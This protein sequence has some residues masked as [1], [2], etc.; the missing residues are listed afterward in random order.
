MP[1]PLDQTYLWQTRLSNMMFLYSNCQILMPDWNNTPW[2]SGKV[3]CEGHVHWNAEC[4]AQL[5]NRFRRLPWSDDFHKK[6]MICSPKTLET[7]SAT[8][9]RINGACTSRWDCG[10]SASFTTGNQVDGLPVAPSNS[11]SFYCFPS[12]ASARRVIMRT[13]EWIVKQTSVGS[14]R[15]I[16]AQYTWP[17]GPGHN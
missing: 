8:S 1:R 10:S 17:G 15:V 7:Y 4:R 5:E 16:P 14:R 2:V 9:G 13:W 3:L 6:D 12:E 11:Q